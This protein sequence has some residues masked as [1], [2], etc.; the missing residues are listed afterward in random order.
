MGV[1]SYQTACDSSPNKTQID[2]W[3]N[4][5]K[6]ALWISRELK[7][8]YGENISDKSI[9]KYKKYRTQNIQNELQNDPTYQKKI[10]ML[11]QRL[12]DGIGQIREVD[13]IAKLAD[14][15]EDCA[16][17][18]ADAKARDIQIRSAQD[19]RFV[20]MTMLDAIKIYNDTIMKAQ[21]FNAIE[22]DP[23]LLRSNTININV[24]SALTDVL[25]EVMNSNNGYDIID[26]LRSGINGNIEEELDDEEDTII[27][28]GGDE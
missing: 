26:K 24:K 12:A 15:I 17:M 21:R 23:S 5:G 1:G 6:P 2:L 7:R 13:V 20:S 22:Q 11:N 14:T 9:L 28:I 27:D 25:K 4:E 10:N 8:L 3:L 16:D 18:L 19:I